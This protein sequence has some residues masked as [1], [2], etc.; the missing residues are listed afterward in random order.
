MVSPDRYVPYSGM[1][2]GLIA[3]QY[4]P[5]ALHIDLQELCRLAGCDFIHGR[6]IRLDA[7]SAVLSTDVRRGYRYDWLSINTGSLP[8]SPPCFGQ[9]GSD[10]TVIGVK[11]IHLFPAMPGNS[12]IT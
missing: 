6:A 4:L 12:H 5:E 3:R 1:L 10:I 9:V 8:Q 11:P 7:D 2:P